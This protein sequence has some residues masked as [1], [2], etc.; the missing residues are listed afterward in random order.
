MPTHTHTL[1]IAVLVSGSGSN[2]QAL[3]D[4][5][6]GEQLSGVEIA[7]V[8]SNKANAQGLQRALKHRLPALYL[9]WRERAE[10]EAKLAV[11]LNLFKTDLIVLAGW[12]RIFS[13]DFITQFPGRIIN[14]HPA[15]IPDAGVGSSFTTRDGSSIPVFRGLHAVRQA[16]DAGVKITGSTVHY[17]T[18]EVDAGPVICREEVTIEEGDTEESL[19]ERL[20]LV[21]HRLVVE[22]VKGFVQ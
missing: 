19:H 17:V 10:A 16:L 14:L 5:I 12:L 7:L 20:K 8:V 11:L 6:E 9:P 3:I 13:A 1:R 2:L 18:P 21:E 15:L 22:A 4:A